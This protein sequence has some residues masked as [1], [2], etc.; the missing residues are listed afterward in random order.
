MKYIYYDSKTGNV[1]RFINKIR[2]LKNW[3]FV[4]INEETVVENKGHL[5][6]FTTN[7]GEV[8]KTTENAIKYIV[9][10]PAKKIF[11]FNISEENI[12]QLKVISKLYLNSKL[13]KEYKL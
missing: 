1:E 11:S 6:T 9:M 4:K 13:E 8:S 5:V 2:P 10:A 7:F 12:T 3:I